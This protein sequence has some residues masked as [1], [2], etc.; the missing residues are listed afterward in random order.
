MDTLLTAGLALQFPVLPLL[1]GIEAALGYRSVQMAGMVAVAGVS[2]TGL[3]AGDP[4]CNQLRASTFV[5][6]V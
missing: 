5:P 6:A 4:K 1:F 3:L 2:G